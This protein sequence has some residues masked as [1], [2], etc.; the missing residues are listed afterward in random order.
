MYLRTCYA[1]RLIK[2]RIRAFDKRFHLF[3]F[4]L[5]GFSGIGRQII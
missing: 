5:E 1:S 4:T 2:Y 3:H